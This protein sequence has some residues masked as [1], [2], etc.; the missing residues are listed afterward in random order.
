M[1]ALSAEEKE[2]HL[3][4]V[5][6]DLRWLES[7]SHQLLFINDEDYPALLREID[8]PPPALWLDGDQGQ[9]T[10][11]RMMVA[12]V[13][14]RKASQYG[15]HRALDFATE[16]ARQ[17][18]VVNSG[19]ALGI[20]AA[21]HEGALAADGLT[22]AVLGT[23]CDVI[24][25]KRHWRLAD[26][27]RENGLIVSEFPPGTKAFPSHFPRRNRIITGLSQA[28]VVVEAGL[29]SGSLVS[30]RIAL[31]QGR[32]VMSVPGPVTHMN[33]KGCHQ[34]IRDGAALVET[35]EDVLRELGL[36]SDARLQCGAYPGDLMP[37][38]QALLSVL[39]ENPASVDQLVYT[40]G[41]PVDEIT[42]N[43]VSLEV[44]GLIYSEAGV[45]HVKT[46]LP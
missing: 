10:L 33:A 41:H 7:S 35:G 16:L 32:E 18:I 37:S 19:L 4:A 15:R 27:I 43:L 9:E 38:E 46:A 45:Y 42:V 22:C 12:I 14:S 29:R 23:G 30:A 34:L 39:R 5:E 6:M 36:F 13:G 21:A 31:S 25:P 40:L 2:K 20:D 1:R 3:A 11:Q 24:Y 17:N 8:D 44:L 26:R 28:V